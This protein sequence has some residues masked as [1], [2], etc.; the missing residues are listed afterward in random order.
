MLDDKNKGVFKSPTPFSPTFKDA[1]KFDVQN[2]V[3]GNLLSQVN[4]NQLTDK[5]VKKILDEGE[6]LKTRARLDALR[7]NTDGNDDDE[8]GDDGGSGGS[9]SYRRKPKKSWRQSLPPPELP[10]LPP[11]ALTTDLRPPTT[12]PHSTSKR[13]TRQ[14]K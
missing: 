13:L 9:G 4:A 10:P 3:I 8:D 1:N 2:P 6:D 11:T 5:Q 14:K 7:N 12:A